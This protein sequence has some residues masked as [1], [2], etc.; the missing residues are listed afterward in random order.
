MAV[1][2]QRIAGLEPDIM[3]REAEAAEQAFQYRSLADARF[4]ELG[5]ARQDG[6][7]II[8]IGHMPRLLE[9]G[10]I[11]APEN[12]QHLERVGLF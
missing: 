6:R 9:T 11:L 7:V 4:A 10:R 1:Q 2:R 5:G 12:S 8:D 3:E